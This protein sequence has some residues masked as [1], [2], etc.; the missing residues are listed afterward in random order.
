MGPAIG[1]EQPHTQQ[2]VAQ[3]LGRPQSFVA[4]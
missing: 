2:Q 1:E 3:K 4:K